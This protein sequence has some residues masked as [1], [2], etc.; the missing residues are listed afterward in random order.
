ML[1][2][3]RRRG[4][5]EFESNGTQTKRVQNVKYIYRAKLVVICDAG[6]QS[7]RYLASPLRTHGQDKRFSFRKG[8]IRHKAKVLLLLDGKG[9]GA[10][11]SLWVSLVSCR[12]FL[13]VSVELSH[14]EM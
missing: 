12:I 1:G 9:G 5:Q 6:R 11:S 13:I 14:L 8:P 4:E 2:F 3:R 7:R 10:Y